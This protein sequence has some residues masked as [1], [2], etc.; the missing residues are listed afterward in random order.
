MTGVQTCALPISVKPV[1]RAD[2]TYVRFDENAAVLV[3]EFSAR[4]TEYEMMLRF[5][6]SAAEYTD[7]IVFGYYTLHLI[8]LLSPI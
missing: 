7:V 6:L 5:C 1:R 3:T 2:G 8:A 4:R